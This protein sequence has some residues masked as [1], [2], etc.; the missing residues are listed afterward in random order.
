ME[1]AV[2]CK[3]GNECTGSIKYTT[4]SSNSANIRFQKST[5]SYTT[6][7]QRWLDH[8]PHK[9]DTNVILGNSYTV[10]KYGSCVVGCNIQ[11]TIFNVK[12]H[13]HTPYQEV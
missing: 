2:N 7:F 4:L 6:T 9:G 3:Q 8:V 13:L 12:G 5:L 1:V 11:F 10:F